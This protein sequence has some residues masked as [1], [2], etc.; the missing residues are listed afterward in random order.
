MDTTV[1]EFVGLGAAIV[2]LAV[3]AIVVTNGG[4]VA[5]ILAASGEAFSASIRAATLR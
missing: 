2:A 3:V 5:K 1:R 4:E